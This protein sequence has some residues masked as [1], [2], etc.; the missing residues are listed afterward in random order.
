MRYQSDAE[1]V[2]ATKQ[3]LLRAINTTL[4]SSTKGR[5][6]SISEKSAIQSTLLE[7]ADIVCN[8]VANK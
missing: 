2:Q 8:Y 4:L 7:F 3:Q 6:L 5:Y 1:M